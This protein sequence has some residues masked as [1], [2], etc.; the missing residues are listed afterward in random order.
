MK[1]TSDKHATTLIVSGFTGTLKNWWD[2]YLSEEN[3]N[4]ILNAKAVITVVKTENNTQIAEQESKEDATAT[5]IYCIAKHFIGEPKLFQDR[6]LELLNNLSCP[7]LTD[8]RGYK[9]MF[10]EKVM[11]RE[12]C[13]K[14]FWKERFF[15]GLPRLFVKKVRTKIR[16]RFNGQIPYDNLTYRDLISFINVT[17][18]DLC[19]DLKLKSLIKK[20]RLQSKAELGSFCQDFGYKSIA[21]PSKRVSKKHRS[22]DKPKGRHRRK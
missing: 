14:P 10:I 5:L 6:S 3:S 16:D 17:G 18:L 21:A 20:D 11:V 19:T 12:D 8:F 22:S 9:D 15:S 4:Q 13:N 7:K 1:N 2:N